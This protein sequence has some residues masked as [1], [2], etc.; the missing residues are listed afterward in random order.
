MSLRPILM[1]P[2]LAALLSSQAKPAK[3]ADRQLRAEA[4]EPRQM[5]SAAG[6]VDV[7]AQPDG[8][9]DGKIAY[10][11]AGHGITAT[12]S[13]WGYQRPLLLDMVEDLGNQD[14]MTFLADYLWNAGATV[15]PLRPVGFQ[16][17]EAVLD[18]DDAGV[19]F[20]GAWGNGAG[21]V[22]FGDSGD[23]RYRFANT[24]LTET[25]VATY[26]PDLP[27]SG[28]YP[29]Y[30]WSP[31][32]SNR[33]TDQLYR[34]RHSGGATEVT[35]D[36]S[37]VGNGLV[38]LGT[39]HFEEGT[40]GAVEISNR[41]SEAGKVVVA[42][43]IRFG[44]GIGDINRGS[45]VSGEPRENEAALYWVEW[46]V[47][48]SQ[49]IPTSAYRISSDDR[50]ATVSVAPRYATYMNQQ[51]VGTLSDRVFVS[52]HSNASTGNPA[53]A[54]ARG[55]L[56][57]HNTDSGGATPNQ[58]LLAETLARQVNDDLVAQ[59]GDFEHN[60]ANRSNVL[61]QAN[62]NYGEISN[63]RINNE[64]DATI[65]ET[66]FH[67]NT[68]D[69]QLLRDQRV[70]D[71]IARSTYHGIVDYFNVVDNG[72]TQNIDAPPRVA[73]LS[74][75]TTAPGQVTLKWQAGTASGFAGG[76]AT[77]Y[78][79]YAST[80]GLGFDGGTFVAGGGTTTH[81][82]TGLT[83][84]ETYYFRVAAVNAGGEA[85]DSEV[86][87]VKPSASP[88]SVLIVNGFDR[89]DRAATPKEDFRGGPSTTD[90][91]R[92][93]GGNTYDYAIQV[94]AAINDAGAT[95]TISTA[96]N[97]A[98]ADGSVS[99]GDYDA[100]VWI[101]GEE[102]SADDSFNPAEQSAVAAYLAGGG[103][104][105]VSGA[106]IAWDLDNLNNGRS[107]FNNSLRADYAADDAGTYNAAGVAGS[108]FE[109]LNLT[110]DDGSQVYDV[111]FPDVI[112]PVGG[113]TAALAYAAGA[114]TAGVQYTDAGTGE[115]LVM[116][117][118]P[119]EA[120][121]GDGNQAEVMAR[122]LDYFGFAT[123]PVQ[124]ASVILDND[125]GAPTY[126]E[127]GSGW[128]TSG[129]PG[130]DGGTQ[131]INLIGGQATATWT[132][133]LPFA[134]D[135]EVF[136]QYDA[137]G[138]RA[139]GVRYEVTV[140]G[141]T[142]TVFVNQQQNDFAW[143]SLGLFPDAAGSVTV[144]LDVENST[145]APFSL[146]IAD[147]VRLDVCGQAN[148]PG[149]DFNRDGIVNAADYTVWRDTF[150]QIVPPLS[151][152]DADGS[153]LVDAADLAIWRTTYGQ[154]TAPMPALIHGGLE[155][156][157]DLSTTEERPVFPAIAY[158]T[159]TKESVAI[160]SRSHFISDIRP[161]ARA[162]L[163]DEALLLFV[164]QPLDV[165]ANTASELNPFGLKKDVDETSDASLDES[166]WPFR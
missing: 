51:G 89:L 58:L 84:G 103:K 123:N 135:A 9:L 50:D 147:Q 116:L 79:V 96:S 4:L 53:T 106:E 88:E 34:V 134:G 115:Q 68:Q 19:T 77:G 112:T 55:V 23:V 78:M 83:A 49:G 162:A 143:V 75:E 57:L 60:W 67:D 161:A 97:E 87:A 24:S 113:S 117:G 56:G 54:S 95:P 100:V 31:A 81:T 5:L 120:L 98:I 1:L 41:S 99:L 46:H 124:N 133:T 107:F 142:N 2:F 127:T 7:G 13:G 141:V 10:V 85:P 63:F 119:F 70:R 69:A 47:D 25:A 64:F 152:A 125:D 93:R 17:N 109:N 163:V 15:V 131:R 20:D 105:F 38:Y 27:E 160:A 145:G 3:T 8:A 157:P 166:S 126:A 16:A 146:T 140:G 130:V 151:G 114:G 43:M 108:I 110:F 30:A 132:G 14:Q 32:G 40:A 44:N 82:L 149:G 101:G 159:G 158:R 153:G 91:V 52:F 59:N 33:A 29:V 35:V 154:V 104:L 48:R 129:D 21:S 118:F 165:E 92:V 12:G 86:V 150:D 39:Y 121:V 80:D 128:F 111:A 11:H 156:P 26:R 37:R 6:L 62:F 90:R 155:T 71:S 136:V 144:T 66:G 122:V 72:A 137:D 74:A 102:S 139:S 28:F 45:G 76:T 148:N 42:D 65:I 61:F 73:A 18:N 22:Y 138:N 164:D 36:H 94:A